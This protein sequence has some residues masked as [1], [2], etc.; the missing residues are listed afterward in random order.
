[1]EITKYSNRIQKFLT[2]EYGSEEKAKT[3]LDTFKE[4]GKDII[5]LSGIEVTEEHNVFLELYAEYRIYQAMGDEKIAALKLESFN[6]FIKNISSFV[7]TKK[8]VETTKKK[9]LM[10]FND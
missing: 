4:E 9:G 3:A 1:M 10:I 6:K 8:E 2:Q 5:K 7:N